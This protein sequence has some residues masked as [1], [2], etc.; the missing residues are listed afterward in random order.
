MPK[1]NPEN[2]RWARESAGLALDSAAHHIGLTGA[3]AAAKLAQFESG[4][5]EPSRR[6]LSAMS[7][8]YRRSLLALYLAEPP[9][10]GARSHDF[11]ASQDR[12]PQSEAAL[13]AL[14]RDVYVRQAL[15][16]SALEEEESAVPLSFVGSV[17]ENITPVDLAQKFAECLRVTL[18]DYRSCRTY[19]EAFSLLRDAVER[20]GIYVQLIGNLGS[21]HTNLSPYH[22]FRGF[23]LADPIA[24]IIVINENDA[25]SSW[26]FTLLHELG[27]I[28]LGQNDISG[29][30]AS[31]ATEK[32]C[33]DAAA[34]FLVTRGEL[35][36]LHVTDKTELETIIARINAASLEWKLSR[37]M[38]AYN[39][40][41]IGSI[42][43]KTYG[44]LA[45]RFEEERAAQPANESASGP[46]YYVVRRHRL[47][48]GLLG[49]VDRLLRSGILTTSKAS[50][51][52][53]VRPTNIQMLM[54]G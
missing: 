49:T 45:N 39:L 38:I 43:S 18:S 24:P 22:V 10:D 31:N 42:S 16:R 1:V 7:K 35:E 44:R 8:A 51:V 32:L 34:M 52:L 26:S 20:L 46:S 23:S 40:M 21:H 27:H 25:K 12:D 33:D 53:H 37:S 11:R 47:G 48:K 41:R 36:G 54:A 17:S 13:E 4:E 28:F 5:R 2:L 3:N 15:L 6:Q 29:Y 30:D 50:R 14:I 19:T 9:R